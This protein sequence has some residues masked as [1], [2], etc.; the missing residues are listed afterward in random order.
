MQMYECLTLLLISYCQLTIMGQ[1][2][3]TDMT[4]D[5]F[6]I[7][8]NLMV[9]ALDSGASGLRLSPG[10]GHCVVFLGKTL[11]SYGASLHTGIYK[12]V[13]VNLIL[14]VT[15]QWTSI[16]PGGSRNIPSRFMQLKPG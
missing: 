9:S 7:N 4:H 1:K 12:W 15:L 14:G 2:L 8:K 13:L 6:C 5:L 16:P 10:Q 3:L 11:N